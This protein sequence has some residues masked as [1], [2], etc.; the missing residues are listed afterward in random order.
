V[1]S[2]PRPR[3]RIAP[4]GG[5]GDLRHWRIDLFGR[6]PGRRVGCRL[7]HLGAI[8]EG[9]CLHLRARGR[10]RPVVVRQSPAMSTS[11]AGRQESAPM[12]RAC[13]L[14]SSAASSLVH[15]WNAHGYAMT[16]VGE[17]VIG[18]R[19]NVHEVMHHVAGRLHDTSPPDTD[20]SIS[21]TRHHAHGITPRPRLHR[22]RTDQARR[23]TFTFISTRI[24]YLV[25]VR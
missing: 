14:S 15:E 1:A 2:S 20:C 11:R 16:E 9:R 5:D 13:M 24:G 21:R 18:D 19:E 23:H 17:R 22:P 25:G 4:R 12:G 6:R 8:V 3:R 10:R 7:G